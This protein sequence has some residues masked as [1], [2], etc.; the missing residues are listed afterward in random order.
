MNS[1]TLTIVLI[2]STSALI[3]LIVFTF[4]SNMKQARY[5]NQNNRAL[6]E[7]IRKSYE[8]QI[9]SLGEK[10]A[11]NEERW[12]DVNHLLIRK[13]YSNESPELNY[14]NKL[15][16]NNFLKSNGITNEDL[17]INKRLVFVLT[18]FHPEFETD[19][20]VIKDTCL[21]VGLKCVRGDEEYFSSD[22]FS[23]MLRYIVNANLVIANINGRN[24]NVLYELGIAQALDKPVILIS[25]E[26][27]NLPIDIQSK[28]FL[29]YKSYGELQDKLRTE[30]IKAL[31]R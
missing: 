31:T 29:I 18:P 17:I 22:I 14:N 28:R 15:V 23:E 26:P 11:R 1:E 30:L 7:S 25:R 16:L 20:S 3:T 4:Y 8:T 27:E 9:Y 6:L 24:S 5:D 10:L 19:Y 12:R 13:E 2:I 21:D